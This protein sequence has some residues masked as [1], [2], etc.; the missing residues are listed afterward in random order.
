MYFFN[1]NFVFTST[2]DLISDHILLP[3]QRERERKRRRRR[4]KNNKEKKKKKKGIVKVVV[5]T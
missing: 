3:V 1:P 4:R 2:A 5:I